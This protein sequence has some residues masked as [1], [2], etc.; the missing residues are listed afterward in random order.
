LL[1]VGNGNALKWRRTWLAVAKTEY[2]FHILDE[3]GLILRLA[4]DLWPHKW[5]IDRCVVLRP[6]LPYRFNRHERREDA[7]SIIFTSASFGPSSV[8]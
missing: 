8:G 5:V 6:G 2:R 3:V 1:N 7:H 4:G